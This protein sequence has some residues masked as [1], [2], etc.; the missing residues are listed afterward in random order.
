MST[1]KH[2]WTDTVGSL[3]W[4]GNSTPRK[5]EFSTGICTNKLS[6]FH[7]TVINLFF[8]RWCLFGD[9]KW[10]FLDFFF[11]GEISKISHWRMEKGLNSQ[12]LLIIGNSTS[13][14]RF[15][16]PQFLA[17]AAKKTR[18]AKNKGFLFRCWFSGTDYFARCRRITRNH[19]PAS[20]SQKKTSTVWASQ[21]HADNWL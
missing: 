1:F 16:S 10:C 15:K 13:A 18:V 6:Y 20:F 17:Y 5:K 14:Y 9:V 12:Q 8:G 21:M 2:W 7:F 19:F 4:M 11:N 3:T